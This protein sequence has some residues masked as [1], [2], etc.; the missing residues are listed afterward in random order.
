MGEADCWLANHYWVDVQAAISAAGIGILPVAAGCKA[1]GPHL[2]MNT[3][4]LQMQWLVEQ[5]ALSYH[6]LLAWPILAYGYYPAFVNYPGS[7]SVDEK[8]FVSTAEA[9]LAAMHHAGITHRVILNNG[10]STIPAL[11]TLSK[12][13]DVTLINVYAGEHY[14]QASQDCIEDHSGGHADE[15]ETSIMLA[16]YPELV[17]TAL[18]TAGMTSRKVPGPFVIDDATAANYCPNGIYGDATRATAAKGQQLTQAML[19]DVLAQLAN[20]GSV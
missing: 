14:R 20:L 9:V 1:H 4:Y 6:S 15:E 12:D 5:L 17:R 13:K 2:P 16:L 7:V 10:I 3:D 11:H 19:H 8:A 18:M